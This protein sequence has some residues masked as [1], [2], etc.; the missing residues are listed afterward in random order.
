MMR[1]SHYQHPCQVQSSIN[2]IFRSPGF[3]SGGPDAATNL[4]CLTTLSNLYSDRL[5]NPKKGHIG[6]GAILLRLTF[7][8]DTGIGPVYLVWKTNI[9]PVY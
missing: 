8:R 6:L 3:L 1:L 5:R 2:I 7:E 4:H 9:L